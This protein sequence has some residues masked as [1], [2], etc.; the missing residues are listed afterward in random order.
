VCFLLPPSPAIGERSLACRLVHHV[1]MISVTTATAADRSAFDIGT[2]TGTSTR[3]GLVRDP[4]PPRS[5]APMHRSTTMPTAVT[6]LTGI[7]QRADHK[8]GG[9]YQ[10]PPLPRSTTA[11]AITTDLR[12][13][14][15]DCQFRT[16]DHG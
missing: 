2:S 12:M 1:A 6:R 15:R 3:T 7:D 10:V 5:P 13:H 11:I 4:R 8:P 16:L 9:R 14:L